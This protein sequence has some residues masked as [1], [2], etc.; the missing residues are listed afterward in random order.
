MTLSRN[1]CA[2][3]LNLPPS[4]TDQELLDAYRAEIRAWTPRT[5]APDPQRRAQAEARIRE[6]GEIRRALDLKPGKSTAPQPPPGTWTPPKSR[7]PSSAP[8][9]PP[10]STYPNP[11][12]PS[13]PPQSPHPPTYQPTHAPTPVIGA[14]QVHHAPDTEDWFA[15]FIKYVIIGALMGIAIY[16]FIVGIFWLMHAARRTGFRARDVFIGGFLILPG[17]LWGTQITWRY[18]AKYRYWTPR[19]EYTSKPLFHENSPATGPAPGTSPSGWH[20]DPM[21]RHQLRFW[22]GSQWTAHVCNDG[23]VSSDPVTR[24]G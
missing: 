14:P 3:L 8:P 7:G 1:E 4:A 2:R 23:I 24:T 15:H 22:D 16:P 21:G 11:P 6:L 18:T 17:I 9:P 19:P 13:W 5:H 20:A 10:S 12:Q